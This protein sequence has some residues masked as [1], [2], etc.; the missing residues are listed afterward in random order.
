MNIILD[1]CLPRRLVRDMH[2]HTVTTA[3]QRGWA[4]LTNGELLKLVE[5]EFDIFITMDSSIVHQQNLKGL[6]ICLIVLHAVNSRYEVL[7]PLI[8]QIR[9]AID[10]ASP[11]SII[12]IGN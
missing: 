12:H 4:S 5:P 1:E 3:P 9:G 10:Q 6:R 11:G 2:D 8:S 7:Q